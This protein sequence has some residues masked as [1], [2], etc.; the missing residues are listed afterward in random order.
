[1]DNSDNF[2]FQAGIE[3]NVSSPLFTK[4]GQRSGVKKGSWCN[5]DE[6]EGL[7]I[8][9]FTNFKLIYII[10]LINFDEY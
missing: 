9:F 8:V 4:G 7:L 10:L 2:V 6:D 1:M 5:M 3:V